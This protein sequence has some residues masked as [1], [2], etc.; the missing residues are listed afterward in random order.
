MFK[1][2]YKVLNFMMAIYTWIYLYFVLPFIL[3]FFLR[4][5]FMKPWTA[6]NLLYS[7]GGSFCLHLSSTGMADMWHP[8]IVIFYFPVTS[9][10]FMSFVFFYLLST[11]PF[12]SLSIL[13]LVNLACERKY[14]QC[15]FLIWLISLNTMVSCPT[16]DPEI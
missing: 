15:V 6:L 12:H 13:P 14:V 7:W 9:I 3:F 16:H 4:Q 2:A 1:L 8:S 5:H 11:P 10:V